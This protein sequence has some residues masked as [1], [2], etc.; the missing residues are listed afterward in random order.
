MSPVFGWLRNRE[1]RRLK[2]E[3][4]AAAWAQQQRPDGFKPFQ[5]T[6]KDQVEGVVAGLGQ[7]LTWSVEP[8]TRKMGPSFV[9]QVPSLSLSVSIYDDTFGFTVGKRN[10]YLE[11]WDYPD[12]AAMIGEFIARLRAQLAGQ[13][14]R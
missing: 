5:V 13:L 1:Q 4:H 8:A 11:W 7:Q 9:G 14:N 2:R 6:A 3:A 10:D 12:P